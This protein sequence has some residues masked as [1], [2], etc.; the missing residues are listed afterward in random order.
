MTVPSIYTEMLVMVFLVAHIPQWGIPT[1]KIFMFRML[2]IVFLVAH[3]LIVR[4]SQFK[5]SGVQ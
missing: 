1:S 4:N 3:I 5:N 2:V